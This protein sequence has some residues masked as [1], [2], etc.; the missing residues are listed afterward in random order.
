MGKKQSNQLTSVEEM[1]FK[2]IKKAFLNR[3]I[4]KNLK[5]YAKNRCKK[6]REMLI[7]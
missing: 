4:R 3:I 1:D 7:Y 2:T 6:Q 5:V